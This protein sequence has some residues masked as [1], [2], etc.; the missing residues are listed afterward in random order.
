MVKTGERDS[1]GE[2]DSLEPV[3]ARAKNGDVRAAYSLLHD[4]AMFLREGADIPR[5]LALY[6]AD[7]FDRI[8]GEATATGLVPQPLLYSHVCDLLGD[9]GPGEKAED[10]L[11]LSRAGGRPPEEEYIRRAQRFLLAL[12]LSTEL[13]RLEARKP[14]RD[15]E[16]EAIKRQ[17]LAE[18]HVYPTP[19]ETEKA[20]IRR[21]KLNWNRRQF[22]GHTTP[23]AWAKKQVARRHS[24]SV[25]EVERA[26]GE[27]GGGPRSLRLADRELGEAEWLML[28]F[29]RP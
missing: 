28:Y 8:T 9:Q 24:V 3:I 7:A 29:W 26:W 13:R 16:W 15:K 25:R 23:R 19:K 18:L 20:H 1:T 22:E 4:A 21:W 10:A 12:D 5:E 17:K 27:Y 14:E 2:D 6:L 11:N